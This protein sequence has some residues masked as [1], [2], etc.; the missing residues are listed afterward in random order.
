MASTCP[1]APVMAPR[2]AGSTVAL[3]RCWAAS[4]LYLP[5]SRPC[6]CTRRAA[7]RVIT[8]TIASRVTPSLRTGSPRGMMRRG[9]GG[10]GWGRAGCGRAGPLLSSLSAERAVV[11]ARGRPRGGPSG[12]PSGARG[13]GVPFSP[14]RGRGGG[15]V[16]RG[17]WGQPAAALAAVRADRPAGLG[18]AGLLDRPAGS[19][20]TGGRPVTGRFRRVAPP[21][22]HWDGG[23]RGGGSAA[24][25][26]GPVAS[27]VEPGDV[28]RRLRRGRLPGHDLS[29]LQVDELQL[30]VLPHAERLGLLCEDR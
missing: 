13:R 28:D 25:G 15:G 4:T 8:N 14:R 30:R 22:W 6:N 21:G 10:R 18:A 20:G 17:L 12:S 7:N 23:R 29:C 16:G 19:G 11:A 26:S 3:S 1:L 2:S 24:G 27:R 9:R 5:D